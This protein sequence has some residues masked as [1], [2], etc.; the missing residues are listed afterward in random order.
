M[1]RFLLILAFAASA[2]LGCGGA[3]FYAAAP[4]PPL[5]A[6]SYGRAPGPGFVWVGGYWGWRGNHYVWVSGGWRRPP[7]RR[8][9][10][11]APYWEHDRGRYRLREGHWR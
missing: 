3:E 6:E 1:K 7:H 9:V 2:T 8:A 10:W 11:V 5:R 4:P